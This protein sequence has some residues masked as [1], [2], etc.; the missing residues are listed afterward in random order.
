MW[1]GDATFFPF[2]RGLWF[3]FS[4]VGSRRTRLF[5]LSF[6]SATLDQLQTNTS[7]SVLQG[8]TSKPVREKNN[9]RAAGDWTTPSVHPNFC[10]PPFCSHQVRS[11]VV[12]PQVL[13]W[14]IRHLHYAGFPPCTRSRADRFPSYLARSHVEISDSGYF[15]LGNTTPHTW[16]HLCLKRAK[17][18]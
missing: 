1:A 12:L 3:F 13:E 5:F 7:V 15:L 16:H 8:L 9:N 11:A 17:K 10:S 18:E 14:K 6:F 2:P 4:F